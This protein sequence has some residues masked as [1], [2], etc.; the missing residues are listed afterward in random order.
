MK[1]TDKDRVGYLTKIINTSLHFG[2]IDR[3]LFDVQRLKEEIESG[4]KD[5]Y[6]TPIYRKIIDNAI[7]AMREMEITDKERLDFLEKN[8]IEIYRV[9]DNIWEACDGFGKSG[10]G[11][12]HREAVDSLIIG[13]H[14][15]KITDKDR[16][17]FLENES[18]SI[19]NEWEDWQIGSVQ[20]C[21]CH[22]FHSEAQGKTL[23]QAIDNAILAMKKR[24]NDNN[25]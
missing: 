17:D 16:L 12:S 9:D 6:L 1:I 15:M 23:R 14:E 7:L 5:D 8:H 18:K 22:A 25:G 20:D 2:L 4:I 19:N 13:L 21:G 3:D 11:S 24:E 10:E